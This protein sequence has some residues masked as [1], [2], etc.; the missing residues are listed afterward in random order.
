MEEPPAKRSR[1]VITPASHVQ[2]QRTSS[3]PFVSSTSTSD[4]S[5]TDISENEI[6]LKRLV[7]AITDRETIDLIYQKLQS[8]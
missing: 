3:I 7:K 5:S 6:L 2:E 4:I 8:P 1:Y